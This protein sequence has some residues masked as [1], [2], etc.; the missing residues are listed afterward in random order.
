MNRL[1]RV[2]LALA[3]LFTLAAVPALAGNRLVPSPTLGVRALNSQPNARVQ[4]HLTPLSADGGST[5]R[6]GTLPPLAC[7]TGERTFTTEGPVSTPESPYY[8]AWVIV[9]NYD[10]APGFRGVQYGIDYDNVALSGVDILDWTSCSP[11]EFPSPGWPASGTGNLQVFDCS[12]SGFIVAGYF[13]IAVYDPDILDLVP[14]QVDDALKVADCGSAETLLDA[15]A[16]GAA[17]FGGEPGQDPCFSLEDVIPPPPEPIEEPEQA[18]LV[19]HAVPENGGASLTCGGDDDIPCAR[20]VRTFV[21]EV[22]EGVDEVIVYVLLKHPYSDRGVGKVGFPLM[23]DEGIIIREWVPC[24]SYE[25]RWRSYPASGGGVLVSWFS[26]AGACTPK[27]MT[28]VGYFRVEVRA[29]G[30]LR[31]GEPPGYPNPG[32]GR[33]IVAYCTALTN[34]VLYNDWV[35]PGELGAVGFGGAAGYDPCHAGGWEELAGRVMTPVRPTTWS[36][37]K[38]LL[39]N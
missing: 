21:T 12:R 28:V 34:E 14:R 20:G 37:L 13:T 39:G 15:I 17:G 23:Y 27:A 33:G 7:A 36:A 16:A 3:G 26:T 30:V 10:A 9:A 2:A 8:L 5:G 6:C 35:L 24:G 19:L 18:R 32:S 29:P 38:S 11:L 1:Q 22:D 31:F 25:D 4:I